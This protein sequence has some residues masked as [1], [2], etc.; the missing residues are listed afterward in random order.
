LADREEI[1]P[2]AKS[3]SKGLRAKQRQT[4]TATM[5]VSVTL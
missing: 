2:G 4:V 5:P 3:K 1:M